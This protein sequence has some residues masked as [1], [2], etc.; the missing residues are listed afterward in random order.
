MN[1]RFLTEQDYDSSLLKWWKDWSWTAPPKDMLPENGAGGLMVSSN[2]IDVCAGFL[3]LT[4]SKTAWVEYIVSNKEYRENERR[5]CIEVLI[6]SLSDIARDKGF[7][8]I[9]TSVKNYH[10]IRK[11]ENCGFIKGDS[12]CQ[13]M[14]KLL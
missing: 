14:I 10:L 12:H 4:N 7:V 11:Y 8:Y 3:Y 9:Y 13:E 1:I 5:E 6:Q 2:G